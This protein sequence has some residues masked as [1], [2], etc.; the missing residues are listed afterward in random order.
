MSWRLRPDAILAGTTWPTPRGAVVAASYYQSRAGTRSAV[1]A[2]TLWAGGLA[3][4]VVAAFGY[5]VGV[6]ITRGVFDIP[7]LA[8]ER[9]G[10]TGDASTWWYAGA[11]FGAALLA[12]ALVHL[13]LLITPRPLKFF[14]WIVGLATTLVTVLPFTQRADLSAQLATAAINLVV[15]IM[16]GSLVRSVAVRAI[17][18]PRPARQPGPAVI[19]GD[20]ERYGAMPGYNDSPYTSDSFDSGAYHGSSDDGT[21]PRRTLD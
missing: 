11:A 1:S 6:V 18:P 16:I 15:G 14:T 21:K 8:P 20:S 2:G 9:A 7:V 5:A 3:T 12:T 10:V 13:L 17:R 4:A 19:M